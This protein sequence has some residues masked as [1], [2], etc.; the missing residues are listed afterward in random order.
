MTH[1]EAVETLASERY[2]LDEMTDVERDAFEAHYFSCEDCAAD[3]RAGAVLREGARAAGQEGSVPSG[4][5][6][7]FYAGARR[8]QP[9]P[10]RPRTALPARIVPWAVAA[11]LAL[12]AAYQTA[13]VIPGL[14]R[15]AAPRAL[16]PV[17]L[18]PAVRGA[19]PAVAADRSGA[20]AAFAVELGVAMTG[21]LQYEL[22]GPGGARVSGRAAAPA[23]GTPLFLL[24]PADS[25]A[26]PGAYT[27]RIDDPRHPEAA[28]V[29]YRFTV[30]A[31]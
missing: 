1:R 9:G 11:S 16:T 7:R 27:L 22:V 21:E 18:R 30:T 3:V 19:V 24:F 29:E 31:Q 15:E 28:A 23:P 13:V 4:E 17:T 8:M 6:R 25:L 2:L 5:V 26:Q 10:P 20:P 14:R 12:V